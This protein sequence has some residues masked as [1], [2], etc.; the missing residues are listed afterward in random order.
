M[1]VE[2]RPV[3]TTRSRTPIWIVGC[4]GLIAL[5]GASVFF[6][7]EWSERK[8]QQQR[9][10]VLAE[11]LR[12]NREMATRNRPLDLTSVRPEIV[13]VPAGA[14]TRRSAPERAGAVDGELNRLF[15]NSP[16]S[17]SVRAEAAAD[18][19]LLVAAVERG[20]FAVISDP[21][22]ND[23]PRLRLDLA[24]QNA[25]SLRLETLLSAAVETG[26]ITPDPAFLTTAG[27]ID[28]RILVY[29]LL[30][31]S[32][33]SGSAANRSAALDLRAEIASLAPQDIDPTTGRRLH[34]VADGDSL[35]YV[36]LLHY[37]DASATA[38][39]IAAN[40]SRLDSTHHVL[41]GQR[42]FIPMS[43]MIR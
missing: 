20:E 35:A 16:A 17:Q 34:I 22:V 6:Y 8:A 38:P 23:D 42:L 2:P 28:T 5:A 1:S 3:P 27:R 40:R 19:G 36:A 4:L 31:K 21:L 13:A 39:I 25:A 12:T 30:L 43:L 26:D 10:A 11:Q 7:A 29:D 33:A 14:V 24:G 41:P 15:A 9:V 18:L 32:L 37:G